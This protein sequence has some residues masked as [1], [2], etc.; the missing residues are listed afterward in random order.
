MTAVRAGSTAATAAVVSLAAPAGVEVAQISSDRDVLRLLYLITGGGGWRDNTNWLTEASLSEWAGV[1]TYTNGCV[2]Y[3][4]LRGDGLDGPIHCSL[5][6]PD[7]AFI[8][9]PVSG[10]IPPEIGRL[11]FLRD[12]RLDDSE[13]SGPPPP[14]IAGPRSLGI[15]RA[16]LSGPLPATF[17][18]LTVDRSYFG[19]KYVCIPGGPR[20]WQSSIA[21]TDD[22]PLRCIPGPPTGKCSPPSAA[23]RTA[24]RGTRAGTG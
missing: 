21:E 9:T 15:S 5:G 3:L 7:H 11:R 4:E 18:R 6:R 10:R 24:R 1:T 14:E 19:R 2:R 22:D 12:L 23:R 16:D 17:A 20:A 8:L 13:L